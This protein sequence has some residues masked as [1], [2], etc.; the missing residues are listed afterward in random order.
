VLPVVTKML[1]ILLKYVIK[2]LMSV[3]TYLTVILLYYKN[4]ELQIG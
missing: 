4:K 3:V 2:L 1:C